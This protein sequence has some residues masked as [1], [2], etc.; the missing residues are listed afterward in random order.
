MPELNKRIKVTI[1]II[2]AA[3]SMLFDFVFRL[4][5]V[6]LLAFILLSLSESRPGAKPRTRRTVS[7]KTEAKAT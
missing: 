7:R 6:L 1:L 4:A 3:L 2:A 5:T